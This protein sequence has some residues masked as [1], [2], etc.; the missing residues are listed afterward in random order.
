MRRASAVAATLALLLLTAGCLGG[1]PSSG[2]DSATPT[3][4]PTDAAPSGSPTPTPDPTPGA[5]PTDEWTSTE[6]ASEVPDADTEVN[7]EN[8]WNRSVEIRLRVVRL[9]TNET[10]HEGTY[11]VEPGAERL[12]YNLAEANPDGIE[13]FRIV[14]TALSTTKRVTV[15]T[16]ACYGN[17]HVEITEEGE[18]YPYYAIC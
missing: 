7:L 6:R 4:T 16:S 8:R 14:A 3:E 1:A 15:E 11:T 2:T 18:L 17:V 9:A 5:T 13:S 10:V 12:V